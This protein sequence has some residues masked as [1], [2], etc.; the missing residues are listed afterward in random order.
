MNS[1]RGKRNLTLVTAH[2]CR[3]FVSRMARGSLS[4][5]AGPIVMRP[6]AH[7]AAMADPLLCGCELRVVSLVEWQMM[8]VRVNAVMLKPSL[9]L[10][11]HVENFTHALSRRDLPES[12]DGFLPVV[13]HL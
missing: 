1:V 3:I 9:L 13:A 7:R 6:P 10:R 2:V 5:P 4:R 11:L 12:E 8:R